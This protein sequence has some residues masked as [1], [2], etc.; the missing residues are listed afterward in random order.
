MYKKAAVLGSGVMGAG[1]AAQ[2]ANNGV[3][4]LLFDLE[5]NGEYLASNAIDELKLSKNSQLTHPDVANLIKAKSLQNDLSEL[6]ECEFIIEAIIEDLG[7]KQN[8][9]QKVQQYLNPEAILASNTSTFTLSDLTSNLN[10]NLSDRMVICHFFNP[11]RIMRLLEFVQGSV[12]KK[13]IFKL[14]KFLSHVMGKEVIYCKD[15]PGFIANRLG[16]YL[17]ELTLCEAIKENAALED[18]DSIFNKLLGFPRTGIFGLYDLIGLD[19]MSLISSSLKNSL[20]KEDDFNSLQDVS[21]ILNTLIARGALGKKSGQGFYMIKKS[22]KG[23]KEKYAL[24]LKTMDYRKVNDEF[25]NIS[26]FSNINEFLSSTNKYSNL[27]TRVL[28]KFFK[29][30]IIH[31]DEF[32]SNFYN[33][34]LAMKLGFAWKL[35]PYEIMSKNKLIP[36]DFKHSKIFDEISSMD[37]SKL[38]INPSSLSDLEVSNKITVLK[39]VSDHYRILELDSRRKICFE[40]KTKMNILTRQVFEGIL[41]AVEFATAKEKDLIIYSDSMHFSAGADLKYFYEIV[42]T[43]DDKALDNYLEL[44][45]RAMLSLKYCTMPVISVA[46]GVA[47]GG[48]CEILLHSDYIVAHQELSAGLVESSL[49]LI[50]GW[51]GLKEILLRSFGIKE[52]LSKNLH[53]IL[54][55]YKSK[56]AL[57]F[58]VNFGVS[59]FISL[60]NIN[61]IFSFAL[62]NEFSKIKDNHHEN[63]RIDI[64]QIQ[65]NQY[66]QNAKNHVCDLLKENLIGNFNETDLLELEKNIFKQL[67]KTEEAKLLIRKYI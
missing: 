7:I 15:S 25:M 29:Y 43:G 38:N 17:L 20:P 27:I 24:D 44:G 23:E 53:L 30:C 64:R 41:A 5:K 37:Y 51:G 62:D 34:D 54:D 31:K 65:L 9:Y 67:I 10:S 61:D 59:N 3:E 11:P 39:E 16:C 47:L 22:A 28:D 21:N 55:S 40:I 1:I 8:L 52:K 18:I 35:G 2:M 60:A 45:Q 58:A 19:V 33:I 26:S 46:R 14:E 13:S 6:K 66:E 36:K 48:G 12:P 56:S 57:D 4:V 50:P 32:T 42:S 63:I 49:G